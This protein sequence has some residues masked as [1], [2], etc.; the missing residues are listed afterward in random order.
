MKNKVLFISIGFA[1][2]A[3]MQMG[4]WKELNPKPENPYD[5]VDYHTPPTPV[6][7]LDPNSFV[8]IHRDI[9]VPKCAQPGCH[10]GVFEPDFR[11]LE[12]S[13]ATLVYAHITKN[14]ADSSFAFRV[15]PFDKNKSVL[16]ERITNCCF[17]NQNDRMPQDNIGVPMESDKIDRIAAWIMGGAKDM[18]G[19]IPQF[20]NSE[21]NIQY[22]IAT[23]PQ[24]NTISNTN[25]RIDSI[26]YNP[27]IV[28]SNYTMNLI[29][30]VSDDST[31]VD[32]LT[33]NKVKMSFEADNFSSSAP[34]YKEF[35][36]FVITNPTNGDKY[37]MATINTNQFASGNIVYFRFYTNDGDHV[38]NTEFPYNSLDLPYKT[39]FSFYIQP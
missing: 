13:Y 34:G 3:V 20:P 32:Q 30:V 25:N 19:N 23:D 37:L 27:F 17:V 31:S 11:S 9:L 12:S 39:F 18:F 26:Y 22:Y 35:Q 14:N 4:C 8:S 21:P 38:G 2:L 36:A 33:Y 24:F 10:D 28:P 6:D 15:I 5:Q 29:F 1:L 7:T 16:Y